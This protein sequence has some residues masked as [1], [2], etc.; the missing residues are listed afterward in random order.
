M[1]IVYATSDLYSEPALVSIKTLL[2]NNVDVDEINIYYIENNVSEENKKLL[3]DLVKEYKRNIKFLP[4]CDNYPKLSG[5]MRTNSIV[6]S[7]CYFQDILPNDVE[8]VLLL[9]SDT[10]VINSLKELYETDL[11]DYWFA[12]VDD[13][14]S[15]WYKRK[16]GMNIRSAY[17]NSGVILFNLKKMREDNFSVGITEVIRE[18]VSKLYY[19]VQDELNVFAE[20]KIKILPPKFNSTTGVFLFNYEDMLRYRIPSIRCSKAEYEEAKNQ[21]VI[22]HFTNNQIIQ[23][24]PWIKGCMHPYKEYYVDVKNKTALRDMSL[25]DSKRSKTS[26]I[27]EFLYAKNARRFIA[28]LLGCVQSFLYPVILYKVMMKSY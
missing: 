16:L 14:K 18:G 15:K 7:Y 5:L 26:R 23:S 20:G 24:R 22:V 21:P 2:M 10:I 13:L 12:A 11:N 3:I 17:I 1:N 9:E 19:E 8:K 25:W 28:I 6:Y 4:M 27:L